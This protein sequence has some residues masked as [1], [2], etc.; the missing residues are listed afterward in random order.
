MEMKHEDGLFVSPA[1]KNNNIPI[2]FNFSRG[3]VAPFTVCLLSAMRYFTPEHNYDIIV[4]ERALTDEQK[5]VIASLI[6]EKS[7][8]SVRYFNPESFF[9]DMKYFMADRLPIEGFFRAAAAFFLT[10]YDKIIYMDSDVLVKADIA[11]L[12]E[13]DVDGFLL[14]AVQDLVAKGFLNMKKKSPYASDFIYRAKHRMGLKDPSQ[15]FNSGV[16]LL[17]C[18]EIRDSFQWQNM[19][20]YWRQVEFKSDDQ[21]MFNALF[22]GRVKFLDRTWNVFSTI[23]PEMEKI[24]KQA[25]EVD[26]EAYVK[27]REAPKIVHF[28]TEMK[29]WCFGEG[30]FVMEYW[31][32][33]RHSPYYEALLAQIAGFHSQV[34]ASYTMYQM[35]ERSMRK[36]L[37]RLCKKIVNIFFPLGTKRHE[38]LK[39]IY[40]QMRGWDYI[41]PFELSEDL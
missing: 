15:Y 5:Q 3:Y 36:R 38:K 4:L 30:D 33:A 12:Y 39:K 9:K 19:L 34:V 11:E 21:D 24:Y 37:F 31:H 23:N 40:F 2:V 6:E 1:Y 32:L 17:N 16:M 13:T 28:I 14:G 22:E 26:Y 27:S 41:P 18:R 10:E 8:V 29:P 35:N 25:P 7:N 20:D